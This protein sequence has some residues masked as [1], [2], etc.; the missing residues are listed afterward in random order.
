MKF[1]GNSK[2]TGKGNIRLI[3]DV[4]DILKAQDGDHILFYEDGDKIIIK[5]G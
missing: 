3:K 5:K 2:V 4:A 1:L